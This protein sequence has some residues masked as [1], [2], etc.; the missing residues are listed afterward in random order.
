M[1]QGHL[2]T[3]FRI[4]S[5]FTNNPARPLYRS[6]GPRFVSGHL[7]PKPLFFPPQPI[8]IHNSEFHSSFL[9][10]LVFLRSVCRLVVTASVVPSSPI[11]FT[12]MKEALSFSET[13]VVTRATWHNIIEDTILHSHRRENLKSYISKVNYIH[14]NSCNR[15]AYI[16]A[17]KIC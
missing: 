1:T 4:H 3:W 2:V 14:I 11:P 7:Q 13:S 5:V 12:M 17:I 16:S 10:H 8:C 6:L 15:S 9:S